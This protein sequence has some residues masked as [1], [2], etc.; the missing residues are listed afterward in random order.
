M[1]A[2]VTNNCLPVGL[3]CVFHICAGGKTRF[4]YKLIFPEC[5]THLSEFRAAEVAVAIC[6]Q[7]LKQ[8]FHQEA[9]LGCRVL[10]GILFLERMP[11][12]LECQKDILE[13]GIAGHGACDTWERRWR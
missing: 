11:A 6:I 5:C 9:L 10:S 4:L 12:A 8:R 7:I 1:T 3:P 2:A 13:A